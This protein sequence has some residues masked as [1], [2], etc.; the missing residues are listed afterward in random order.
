[1]TEALHI[2]TQLIAQYLLPVLGSLPVASGLALTE[3]LATNS[4]LRQAVARQYLEEPGQANMGQAMVMP[5]AL[6]HSFQ[7]VD[8]ADGIKPIGTHIWA[9]RSLIFDSYALLDDTDRLDFVQTLEPGPYLSI[10]YPILRHL[11]AD[12]PVV[13][14]AITVL[15]RQQEHQRRLHDHLLHLTPEERV[16]AFETRYKAFAH[17]ATIEQRC[18]H[19]GLTRQT[20]SKKLKALNL[21]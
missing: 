20:Y 2:K 21:A 15:A 3:Q 14:R 7:V 5:H 18:M 6:A 4:Q 17:V 8:G 16:E 9:R 13:D 11:L 1:M 12:Y 10:Q 19:V